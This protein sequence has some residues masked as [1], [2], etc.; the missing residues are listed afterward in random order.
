MPKRSSK[1]AVPNS[2]PK[3]VSRAPRRKPRSTGRHGTRDIVLK[4]G[5]GTTRRSAL[6]ATA[7]VRSA[8]KL[9]GHHASKGT[10]SSTLKPPPPGEGSATP[11]RGPTPVA[12]SDGAI[13]K[14]DRMLAFL[15]D[16]DNA[17]SS[18]IG[19]MLEEASK[20]G[21]LIIRR[22]YGDWTSPSLQSWRAA[23]HEHA[24][25]PEQQF[26]NVAGKNATDSALIIDAMDILHRG[27][28]R[29][30]C[31]V[32]S[33]SDY[34]RLAKRI[35]EEGFFVMGIGRA[36]TP[37]TFRNACHVF[38]STETLAP[39]AETPLAASV[40]EPPPKAPVTGSVKGT[41]PRAPRAVTAATPKLPPVEALPLLRKAFDEVVGEDGR[42]LLATVGNTL[43]KLDPAFDVRTY[44]RPGLS[45][46]LESL[47]E[48]FVLERSKEHGPGVI[49]V[50]LKVPIP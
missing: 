5:E 45:S 1:A 13:P 32:S 40:P 50:R 15:V 18:L 29:G 34:T 12:A 37:A 44:G 20:Y 4:V 39:L 41:S 14:P 2:S 46:L 43:Q 7:T 25:Y 49:H 28:V 16:G 22:V 38:V 26:S 17:V 42:A 9:V 19:K 36:A 3:Q 30:F 31:I 10:S 48:V 21:T 6:A 23:L 11:G 24:L 33:D 8:R 27:V 35:R 47:P